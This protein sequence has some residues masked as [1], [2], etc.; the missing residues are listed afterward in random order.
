M[1]VAS[2]HTVSGFGNIFEGGEYMAPPAK[3]MGY[4]GDVGTVRVPTSVME[5]LG[6]LGQSSFDA[7]DAAIKASAANSLNYYQQLKALIPQL[8]SPYREQAQA[9][10]DKKRLPS[11]FFEKIFGGGGR[12]NLDE[13]AAMMQDYINTGFIQ[14]DPKTLQISTTRRDRLAEF[15]NAVNELAAAIPIKPGATGSA[16]ALLAQLHASADAARKSHTAADAIAAGELATVTAQTATVEGQPAIAN[17]ANQIKAEMAALAASAPKGLISSPEEVPWLTIG[18]VGGGIV[19][20]LGIA[21]FLTK[22]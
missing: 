21:Y 7:A 6:Y 22:K 2:R 1:H 14:I 18:L 9:I 3:S 4:F 17:E 13:L 8:N 16:S 10:V 20:V 15:Q 11:N 12:W 5:G 19:V